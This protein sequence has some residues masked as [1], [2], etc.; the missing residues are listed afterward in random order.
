[1]CRAIAG[2][3]FARKLAI[4]CAGEFA[5]F[6]AGVV[7]RLEAIESLKIY[8][9]FSRTVSSVVPGFRKLVLAC[10]RAAAPHRTAS[11][12]GRRAPHRAIRPYGAKSVCG[13]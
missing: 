8:Q 3:N 12:H 4:S 2:S 1:M 13:A 10:I 9:S 6:R 11:P 7:L 5:A